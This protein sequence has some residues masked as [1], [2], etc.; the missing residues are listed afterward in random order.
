MSKTNFSNKCAILGELWMWYK[1]TDNE[2]WAEFFAWGDIGLPLSYMVKQNLATAKADGKSAIEEVWAAF[3][4]MI[5]IDPNGKYETLA[6]AF[7]A[8]PNSPL[9]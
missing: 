8:S 3:C 1:D 9:E 4:E 7:D 2:S 6:D 5:D